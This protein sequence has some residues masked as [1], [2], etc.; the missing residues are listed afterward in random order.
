[1]LLVTITIA[2][3]LAIGGLSYSAYT[4]A[5]KAKDAQ[6][7]YESIMQFADDSALQILKLQKDNSDLSNI[8]RDLK[9]K[10]EFAAAKKA[11]KAEVA[12]TTNGG[13]VDAVKPAFKKR[14][15]KRR[16]NA[17]SANV[18]TN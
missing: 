8:V 16:P 12:P 14:G 18:K 10:L 4:Y 3:F 9:N 6:I 11:G 13:A 2:A 17:N 1:M 5:R 15:R 7:K